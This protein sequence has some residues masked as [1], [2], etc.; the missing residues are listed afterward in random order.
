MLKA[1]MMAAIAALICFSAMVVQVGAASADTQYFGSYYGK[2]YRNNWGNYQT[3]TIGTYAY[4]GGGAWGGTYN[5]SVSSQK[6]VSLWRDSLELTFWGWYDWVYK[7]YSDG[8]SSGFAGAET[9]VYQGHCTRASSD[10]YSWNGS[11]WY[12]LGSTSDGF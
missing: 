11:S 2:T 5:D 3:S 7:G 6:R 1:A 10:H 8:Y 9:N 12:N 4:C